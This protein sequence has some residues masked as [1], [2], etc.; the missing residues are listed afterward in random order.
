MAPLTKA[1]EDVLWYIMV[2]IERESRPPTL[3]QIARACGFAGPSGADCHV[4]PLIKKLFLYRTPSRACGIKPLAAAKIWYQ[5][6][7]L[8][9]VEG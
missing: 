4:R 6:K 1:Q 8:A 2:E 7:K 9:E 5:A 3:S